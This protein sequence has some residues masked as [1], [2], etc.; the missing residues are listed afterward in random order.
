[1]SASFAWCCWAQ[2]QSHQAELSL[3]NTASVSS[4]VNQAHL[5]TCPTTHTHQPPWEFL[6]ER[7]HRPVVM[8]LPTTERIWTLTSKLRVVL[9]AL[10]SLFHLQN[11]L[12]WPSH[13]DLWVT[14][15]YPAT[16]L[17]HRL[18]TGG[19]DSRWVLKQAQETDLRSGL[20]DVPGSSSITEAGLHHVNLVP[21]P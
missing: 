10:A 20:R 12:Y 17:Q 13:N 7:R 4:E 9:S 8:E 1:M 19:Q 18:N 11:V 2:S 3:A 14:S 5:C 15:I 16:L 6:P 21:N